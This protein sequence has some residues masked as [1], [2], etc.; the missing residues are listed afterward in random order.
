MNESFRFKLISNNIHKLINDCSSFVD[1]QLKQKRGKKL[2]SLKCFGEQCR[3][4][5]S[6]LLMSLFQQF[7]R[8]I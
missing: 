3:T 1:D 6:Y 4:K 5:I 7:E 2:H 8:F